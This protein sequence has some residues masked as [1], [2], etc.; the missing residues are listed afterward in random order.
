LPA[1]RFFNRNFASACFESVFSAVDVAT[2]DLERVVFLLDLTKILVLTAFLLAPFDGLFV[3][4]RARAAAVALATL[5]LRLVMASFAF[6]LAPPEG[7]RDPCVLAGGPVRPPRF[8]AFI[9]D[10][11][12]A[13]RFRADLAAEDALFAFAGV[14]FLVL[15]VDFLRVAI[16]KL[17]THDRF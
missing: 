4:L 3:A 6:A 8:F 13:T 17:S 7:L 10:A 1:F 12:P 2:F 14:D 11:C 5:P 15:L 9:E 16:V